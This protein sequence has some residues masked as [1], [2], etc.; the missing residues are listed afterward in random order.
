MAI[1]AAASSGQ[2]HR[3]CRSR[4]TPCVK[5]RRTREL[6]VRAMIFERVSK[7]N[8]RLEVRSDKSQSRRVRCQSPNA[9]SPLIRDCRAGGAEERYFHQPKIAVRRERKIM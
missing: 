6:P 2:T 9:F 3:F 1:M 4:P 8:R 5:L 7:G